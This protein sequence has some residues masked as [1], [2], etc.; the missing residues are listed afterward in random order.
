ML[1]RH[2]GQYPLARTPI[3]TIAANALQAEVDRCYASGMDGFLVKPLEIR[4]LEQ[5]IMQFLPV[6]C[7][8]VVRLGQHMII[9]NG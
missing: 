1:P 9:F 3:V 8:A 7:Y 2:E 4:S 6:L 5:K